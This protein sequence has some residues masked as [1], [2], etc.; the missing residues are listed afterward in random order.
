MGSVFCSCFVFCKRREEKTDWR[1]VLIVRVYFLLHF[2][3]NKHVSVFCF[4]GALHVA[5][6]GDWHPG[7]G[8]SISL[9]LAVDTHVYGREQVASDTTIAQHA[10][11]SAEE[12]GDEL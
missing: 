3:H 1:R 10:I 7:V 6:S 11:C 5:G 4:N 12:R 9:H 8:S 2:I